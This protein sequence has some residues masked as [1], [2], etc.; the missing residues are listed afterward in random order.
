M[1][2]TLPYCALANTDPLVIHVASACPSAIVAEAGGADVRASPT[3]MTVNAT[4][5]RAARNGL[6]MMW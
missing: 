2:R 1:N 6:R 4:R 3:T 5:G